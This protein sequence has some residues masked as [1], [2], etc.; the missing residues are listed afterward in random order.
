[1]GISDKGNGYIFLIKKLNSLVEVDSKDAKFNET[2]A[3]VRERQGKL[4]NAQNIE[5]D[6]TTECDDH[7]DAIDQDKDNPNANEDARHNS[8]DNDEGQTQKRPRRQPSPRQLLL[9]GTHNLNTKKQG[10]RFDEREDTML[11]HLCAATDKYE[12]AI[13]MQP[14]AAQQNKDREINVRQQQYSH[15]CLEGIMNEYSGT[16]LILDCMEAQT[17]PETI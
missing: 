2:F 11:R 3:D 12:A 16:T 15:L 17:T 7:Y 10:V 1:V 13:A 5:P 4:T 6:L 8:G 14:E 9:P